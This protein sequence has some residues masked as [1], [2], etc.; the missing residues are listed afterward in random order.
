MGRINMEWIALAAIIGF[1]ASTFAQDPE[2]EAN[3]IND[4]VRTMSQVL[5]KSLQRADLVERGDVQVGRSLFDGGVR[6]SYVPTVGI[7]FRVNVGFPIVEPK[8]SPPDAAP[9][10]K[11]EEEDTDLWERYSERGDGPVTYRYRGEPKS[12]AAA[13]TAE[14]IETEVVEELIQFVADERPKYDPARVESLRRIVI[15]TIGKYGHRVTQLKDGDR[16]LVVVEAPKERTFTRRIQTR[17]RHPEPPGPGQP[18][19]PPREEIERNVEREFRRGGGPRPSDW[20]AQ[21]GGGMPW[22]GPR[23]GGPRDSCLFSFSK[24]DLAAESNYDALQGKV[25]EVRY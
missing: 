22:G 8:N 17:V 2:P 1:G 19:E 11:Q 9:E 21:G 24:P 4:E 12:A 6:G 25:Q 23:G 13:H 18:G 15:E 16:V 14:D 10:P 20:G 5:Q 3:S 7:I